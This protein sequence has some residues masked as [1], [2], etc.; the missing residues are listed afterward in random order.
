MT[1]ADVPSE[2]WYRLLTGPATSEEEPPL[3]VDDTGRA[4]RVSTL[5]AVSV[6]VLSFGIA[7]LLA[8]WSW[9]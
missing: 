1:N 5:I 6:A 4:R 2:E 3:L 8:A 7:V 9:R